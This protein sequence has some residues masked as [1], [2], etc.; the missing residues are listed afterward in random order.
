VPWLNFTNHRCIRPS[1]HGIVIVFFTSVARTRLATFCA[2][3]YSCHIHRV[4]PGRLYQLQLCVGW[5]PRVP[6]DSWQCCHCCFAQTYS[7]LYLVF[8]VAIIDDEGPKLSLCW[9]FAVYRWL[10]TLGFSRFS[11]ESAFS[12]LILPLF[13]GSTTFF[14]FSAGRVVSTVYR[15]LFIFRPSIPTPASVFSSCCHGTTRNPNCRPSHVVKPWY[16]VCS[17]HSTWILPR[18]MWTLFTHRVH[19][20]L[21]QVG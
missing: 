1:V 15:T 6:H 12:V 7:S 13:I 19:M 9:F 18:C 10:I 11:L 2:W 21:N 16:D 17:D 14:L 20:Y 4:L 8:A 3:T 5:N